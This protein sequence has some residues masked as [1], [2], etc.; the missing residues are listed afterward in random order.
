VSAKEHLCGDGGG[1]AAASGGACT[2]HDE[3]L[4]R[5]ARRQL[6]AQ[7][8]QALEKRHKKTLVVIE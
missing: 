3:A 2:S 5:V 6:V 1:A 7:L 4:Y 8:P